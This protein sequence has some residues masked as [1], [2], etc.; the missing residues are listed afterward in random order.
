MRRNT[1]TKKELEALVTDLGHELKEL[2]LKYHQQTAIVYRTIA[3]FL[4]AHPH[5]R[6]SMH[7]YA[8]S[9]TKAVKGPR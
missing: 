8:K 6:K 3:A 4:K 7:E 5:M 9:I 2:R 1:P